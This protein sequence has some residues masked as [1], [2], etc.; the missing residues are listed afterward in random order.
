MKLKAKT[1]S[2]I[3]AGFL[4]L[5]A[6]APS[7][8]VVPNTGANA[9]PVYTATSAPQSGEFST[10]TDFLNALRN[11]GATVQ[12]LGQ[13]QQPYFPVAGQVV[14][15]NGVDIQV[16][17]FSSAAARKQASDTISQT[18]NTIGSSVPT[19]VDQPNF[20]AQGNL[21]VLYVGHEPGILGTL[22]TVLGQPLVQGKAATSALPPNLLAN[23]QNQVAKA[24]N[25]AESEVQVLSVQQVQWPN[26][27][28]GLPQLGE[29]CAQ[30]VT[31]G[32]KVVVDVAGQQYEI[33]ANQDGS[34][35]R[36]QKTGS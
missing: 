13:I 12:T 26:A 8:A 32:Y 33:R 3:V 31:P 5:A 1:F 20:W 2:I 27:C 17:E 16:F 35:I 28:L 23:A 34:L 11:Y 29:T 25:L 15:V 22:N 6:C 19:W 4:L 30:V 21:I 36:W 14:S 7:Q 18:A 10:T 24:L 9:T